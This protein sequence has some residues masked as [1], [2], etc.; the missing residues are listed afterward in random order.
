MAGCTVIV[1][2][3]CV[4]GVVYCIASGIVDVVGVVGY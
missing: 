4:T 1:G 3:E 2:G